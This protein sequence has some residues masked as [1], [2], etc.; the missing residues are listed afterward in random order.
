MLVIGLYMVAALVGSLIPVNADWSEQPEGFNIYLYDN[1]IHTSIIFPRVTEAVYFSTSDDA[2]PMEE[3]PVMVERIFESP[4]DVII[5]WQQDQPEK[6]FPGNPAQ[7]PYLM[8]GWG[9]ARF[10]RET[11]QWSDFR[12]DTALAA[13]AGSGKT[14]VHVERLSRLPRY[15]I[16]KIKLSARELANLVGFIQKQLQVEVNAPEP[17]AQNGYSAN[18]RFFEAVREHNY[19]VIFTCN[20]WISKGLESAG[21]KT[22]LWTPLPFGVMWW[23]YQPPPQSPPKPPRR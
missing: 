5:P 15:N 20:N 23:H 2:Q 6:L 11:P 7:Y 9:D 12:S 3:P 18:D 10:Y 17:L 4:S 16:R 19:S 13:V 1:G 14:L 8:I 21:V 22:A